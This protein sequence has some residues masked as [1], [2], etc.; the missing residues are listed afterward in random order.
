MA[1]LLCSLRDEVRQKQLKSIEDRIILAPSVRLGFT[2]A[3]TVSVL[4]PENFVVG[5]HPCVVGMQ[6]DRWSRHPLKLIIFTGPHRRDAE[7]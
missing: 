6:H 3:N 5:L 4:S 1:G 2:L 7:A